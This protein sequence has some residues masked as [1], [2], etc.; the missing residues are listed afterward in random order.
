MYYVCMYVCMY[1]CVRKYVYVCIHVC[2][3]LFIYV[4]MYVCMCVSRAGWLDVCMFVYKYACAY[5]YIQT[6]RVFRHYVTIDCYI[7]V[8]DRQTNK[9]RLITR[10]SKL[11]TMAMSSQPP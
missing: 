3:Y 6:G 5:V 10:G 11:Q 4:Y 8:T 7:I 1:V 2:M 9:H